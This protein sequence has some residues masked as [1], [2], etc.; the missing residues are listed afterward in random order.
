LKFGSVAY[1]SGEAVEAGLFLPRLSD[2]FKG[3]QLA[4]SN[5]ALLASA[6]MALRR[7]GFE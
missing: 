3:V 2:R 1:H 4:I 7:V 5:E 6:P